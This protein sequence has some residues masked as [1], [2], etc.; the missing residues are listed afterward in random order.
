MGETK[1]PASDTTSPLDFLSHVLFRSSSTSTVLPTIDVAL[2]ELVYQV[3]IERTLSAAAGVSSTAVVAAAA[4]STPTNSSSSLSTSTS[5]SPS[6]SPSTSTTTPYL[7]TFQILAFQPDASENDTN[8]E[9]KCSGEITINTM[10]MGSQQCTTVV[11]S[12][13][14][15]A[16]GLKASERGTVD[17]KQESI[18][19]SDGTQWLVHA[20][21]VEDELES[22]VGMNVTSM[23]MLTPSQLQL[24][25]IFAEFDKDMDGYL[26]YSE[27]V[28]L[29]RA[30]EEEPQEMSEE[31]FRQI[32][33]IVQ[34]MRENDNGNDNDNDND[35]DN[36]DQS[37]C[38]LDLLDLTCIYVGPVAEM[39]Q[40]NLNADF[41]AV[42]PREAKIIFIFETFDFDQDGFWSPDEEAQYVSR[43]GRESDALVWFRNEDGSTA[44]GISSL[45]PLYL[46]PDSPFYDHLDTDFQLT[47]ELAGFE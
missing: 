31:S 17:T 47:G 27:F 28:T 32:V 12:G 20:R 24:Q 14:L 9:P 42:F 34:S 8:I 29:D 36:K 1:Q 13:D 41:A 44:V 37:S 19:W 38:R 23:D 2:T 5:T 40:T 11:L 45:M 26:N 6:T 43:T 46:E 16:V 35:N 15:S 18:T 21:G 4:S 25:M 39:F 3:N 7:I 30:T 22:F 10:S 33:S